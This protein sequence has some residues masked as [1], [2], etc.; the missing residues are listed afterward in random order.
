MA[1]SQVDPRLDLYQA[2]IRA[3]PNLLYAIDLSGKLIAA[4][5]T[6][7]QFFA[8]KNC[9]EVTASIYTCLIN[10]L[11][12]LEARVQFIEEADQAVIASGKPQYQILEAPVTD[13]R[14]LV[15]YYEATRVPL[16]DEAGKIIGLSVSFV[17][18]TK[19]QILETQ[20]QAL[21][22]RDKQDKDMPLRPYPPSVHRDMSKPPKILVIEDNLIAQHATEG[23]LAELACQVDL[24]ASAEDA[25]RLFQIGK[26]DVILMDIG[27]EGTSGYMVAK[28]IRQLEQNTGYCVPIIALTGFDADVV[29]TDCD[30]YFMEGAMTKPLNMEQARQIIQRY[31]YQ[32]PVDITGLKS[33]RAKK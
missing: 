19:R 15:F 7:L 4:S 16:R 17:D 9:S 33:L 11:H 13:T 21:T 3:V 2:I 10:H 25:E 6:L 30:Y 1:K 24:A 8:V 26:Y 27:L 32:E 28:R 29:K 14:G 31:V 22:G 18:V 23:I 20:V 5:G 12:W